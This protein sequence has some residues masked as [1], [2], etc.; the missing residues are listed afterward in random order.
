MTGVGGD[1]LVSLEF[2]PTWVVALVCSAIVAVSFAAERG[3][4]YTGKFLINKKQGPLYDALQKIKEV[5]Q[6]SISKICIAKHFTYHWLPCKK[7]TDYEDYGGYGGGG[8]R[9]LLVAAANATDHCEKQGKAPLLSLRALYDLHIFIFVLAVVHVVISALTI[10]FGSLKMRKW[11]QWEDA[12]QDKEHDPEQG[13]TATRPCFNSYYSIPKLVR[14]CNLLLDV[15]SVFIQAPAS[16]DKFVTI[17]P[18]THNRMGSS[19]NKA[20]FEEHIQVKL[21]GW[22]EKAKRNK[23]RQKGGGGSAGS[24]HVGNNIESLSAIPS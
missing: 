7:E 15:G 12:I 22:A 17:I 3:L 13:N 4:Y 23:G 14:D 8:R 2:A 11:K 16:W 21:T 20:I 5:C 18:Q 6:D 19:F 24:S 10:L 9:R 1:E